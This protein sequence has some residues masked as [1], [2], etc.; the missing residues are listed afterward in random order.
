[1]SSDGNRTR[2]G[3]DYFEDNYRSN[4]ARRTVPRRTGRQTSL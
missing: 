1:M 3:D 2:F 4:P